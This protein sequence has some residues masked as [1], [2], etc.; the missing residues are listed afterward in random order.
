MQHTRYPKTFY[1]VMRYRSRRVQYDG[2][3]I[4]MAARAL[5]PGT[6]YGTGKDP[7]LARLR[8]EHSCTTAR[9]NWAKLNAKRRET[10]YS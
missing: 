10:G 5:E 4:M 7:V 9:D 6:C 1:T 8:C 2:D 3:S